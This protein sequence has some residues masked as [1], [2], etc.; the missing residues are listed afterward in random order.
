[1]ERS[2]TE[3][4]SNPEDANHG[5]SPPNHPFLA[6][7]PN[8][9]T[10][11]TLL[12]MTS[13]SP[14]LLRAR[15]GDITTLD[16]DVI[17]NA[18]NESLLGGG[19]VDGAI[20]AAAGPQL[21]AACRRLGGCATG[22]AKRTLGFALTARHVVHAVGPV[23]SGGDDG[24][25]ELLAACYRRAIELAAEVHA[26]SIAFPCISTGVYGYPKQLAAPLAI[27]AVRAAL[28]SA[29]T[30]REVVFCCFGGD[31]FVRY[32]RLLRASDLTGRASP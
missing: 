25:P 27:D 10:T 29:P 9:A 8:N 32:E 11:T 15:L 2:L 18:A 19:G 24:E 12:G 5:N 28:P 20:H 4:R 17:V 6:H 23:W 1:V 3:L 31:D 21:L 22:D 13:T 14:P 26:T 16:V 30:L 7:R